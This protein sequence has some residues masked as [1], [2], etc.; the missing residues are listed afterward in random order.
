MAF[1]IPRDAERKL[2]RQSWWADLREIILHTSRAPY[3]WD[4]KAASIA[5]TKTTPYW[6]PSVYVLSFQM[7]KKYL[8]FFLIKI[9][10][11]LYYSETEFH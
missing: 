10:F 4:F 5:Q 11:Y 3:S 6:N 1:K 8:F 7:L 9:I 2:L